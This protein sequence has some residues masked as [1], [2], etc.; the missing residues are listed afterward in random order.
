MNTIIRVYVT[1]QTEADQPHLVFDLL[2]AVAS[3]P[4]SLLNSFIAY[5]G[6]KY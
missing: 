2:N 5:C 4:S 3:L 1:Q 6:D